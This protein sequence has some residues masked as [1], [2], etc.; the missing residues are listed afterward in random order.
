MMRWNARIAFWAAVAMALGLSACAQQEGPAAA[1][2]EEKTFTV[3]PATASLKVSF[4]TGELQDLKI[5]ERVEQGSGR[6]V[7]PPTLRARLVLRNSSADQAARLISGKIDYA[8]AEGR[9]IPL[10][11][12]RGDTDFKFYSYQERLDPGAETSQDIEVP[13]PAAALKAKKLRD[14]RL[15]LSYI[16]T[17]YR[18]ETMSI[19]VS[20]KE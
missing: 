4:L 6:V 15:E 16:P 14:I 12:G 9:P 19:R 18:E 3:T 10:A 8:D 5:L 7:A 11:E 17:P 20:V 1:S 2:I 13:F